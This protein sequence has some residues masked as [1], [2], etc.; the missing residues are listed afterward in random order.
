MEE[1]II[2]NPKTILKILEAKELN[3]EKLERIVEITSNQ[4]FNFKFNA[5]CPHGFYLEAILDKGIYSYEKLENF[6][7]EKKFYRGGYKI[8]EKG[9]EFLKIFYYEVVVDPD[10]PSEVK[11]HFNDPWR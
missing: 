1:F 4:N 7:K 3:M 6:L 10:K 9:N 5:C 8:E 2:K 11:I